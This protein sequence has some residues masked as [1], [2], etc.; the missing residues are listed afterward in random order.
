MFGSILKPA[1]SATICEYGC[2]CLGIYDWSTELKIRA[3]EVTLGHCG[4]NETISGCRMI[5][6]LNPVI[7]GQFNTKRVC[8]KPAHDNFMQM[9]RPD[10][11]GRCSQGFQPC[12]NR[13]EVK[14]DNMVCVSETDPQGEN[15]SVNERCPINDVQVL[16]KTQVPNW[17]QETEEFRR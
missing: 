15:R 2:D 6:P 16:K 5:N 12:Q 3:D 8:G 7:M 1:A 14:P 9:K 10:L 13:L 17:E 11:E 4:R